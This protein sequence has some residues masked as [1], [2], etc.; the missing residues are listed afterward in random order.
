MKRFFFIVAAAALLCQAAL[1]IAQESDEPSTR[2]VLDAARAKYWQDRSPGSSSSGSADSN[3]DAADS[4]AQVRQVPYTPI[5]VSLVPGLSL[6]AGYYDASIA[7]GMVGTLAGD[8]DGAAGSGV[9]NLTRDVRGFE[10][11]GVF[12]QSRRVQGFQS[13]GVFNIVDSDLAGFQGA[14]V[15][16]I[17]NGTL[18]GFQGAGVFNIGGKVY[19]PFQ[20]AGV[21]NIAREVYGFQGAG[22]FNIADR[23]S[24]GQAA[25]VFN[26]AHHV[27]GVQIGLVNVADHIDGVQLGLINIAGNGV[28]SL[29]LTYQPSTDFVY[30]H[31]QEGTPALYTVAGLGAPAGDWGKDINGFVASLGLGSRTRLFGFTIDLDISAV[32]PLAGMPMS[33]KDWAA[34]DK[35][36][37]ELF[38]PYPSVRL[39]AGL[40]LGGHL[41]IVGGLTAD[42]DF[43]GL[44]SRVPQALKTAD[45]WRGSLFGEGFDA[46]YKW[47]FGLKI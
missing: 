23:V 18:T 20:A 42:I 25:G 32:Q 36:M 14:G 24:G 7:G 29:G 44:G 10:T 2:S 16:N 43:D 6:P 1:V 9:F 12:N 35:T 3:A 26:A 34:C 21:F 13:A 17:T 28:G 31:L 27:S 8:I 40:P 46:Y 45:S 4:Q 22:V 41:Q 30:A 15:F 47:F 5:L 19:A 33:D 39:M 11:A 38:R 37:E